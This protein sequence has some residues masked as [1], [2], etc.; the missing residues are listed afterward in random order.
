MSKHGLNIGSRYI[1][2]NAVMR[3]TERAERKIVKYAHSLNLGHR[4]NDES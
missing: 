2:Y 1:K 3:N 4:T